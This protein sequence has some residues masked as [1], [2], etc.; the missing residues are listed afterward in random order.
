V[1]V[2]FGKKKRERL[3]KKALDEEIG[4]RFFPGEKE[5]KKRKRAE[6]KRFRDEK[7]NLYILT[8]TGHPIVRIENLRP[9]FRALGK[10]IRQPET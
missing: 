6:K 2:G 5:G 1:G 9:F 4:K 3:L 10:S 8:R 7:T